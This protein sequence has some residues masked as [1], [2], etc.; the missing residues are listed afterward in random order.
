MFQKQN[1]QKSPLFDTTTVGVMVEQ[2][3]GEMTV[4]IFALRHEKSL[5]GGAFFRSVHC[6]PHYINY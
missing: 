5:K 1:G 4:N 3:V 6:T 2:W